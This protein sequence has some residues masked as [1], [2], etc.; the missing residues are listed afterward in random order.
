MFWALVNIIDVYFVNGVYEN[1]LDGTMIAGL[2]QII[3]WAIL[4][5]VV[6]LKLPSVSD[7]KIL[8]LSFVGGILYT[9]SF[10]F[11]FKALFNRNDVSLLQILWNLTIIAVPVLSFF[12]FGEVL[13]AYKYL[14]MAIVLGGATIL[15]FN[16]KI[17]EKISG[18]YVGIMMGAVLFLSVSMIME[19]KAYDLLYEAYGAQGFWLGFLC[20]SLGAFTTGLAFAVFA[21]RSP[22]SLIRKYYKVFLLGEGIYFLGN[23]SSQKA[24]DVAPSASYVAVVETFVPVFILIYSLLILL[25]F[26]R[27]FKR[28]SEVIKRIYTEQISGVW[29]KVFATVIMALGVYIIS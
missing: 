4:F 21:R 11:Y 14:G 20:F 23:L 15:S 6:D 16:P 27:I 19:G 18:R 7:F 13:P 8:W 2:F 1:E 5:F 22:L 3:P 25:I 9:S 17:R 29:T 12:I 24:L 10:Y 26:Y 28:E